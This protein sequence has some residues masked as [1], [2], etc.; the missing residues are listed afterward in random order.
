M[1]TKIGVKSR[2]TL[3]TLEAISGIKLSLGSLLLAIREGD[4]MT[5]VEFAYKL[6]VSKQ[7]L[8]DLEHGRKVISPKTAAKFAVLLGYSAAQFVKLA[9]QDELDRYHIP[10]HVEVY[11]EDQYHVA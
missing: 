5:Q 7:Y 10:L 8:C 9:I 11:E 3:R 2:Q 6:G 1:S 4:E